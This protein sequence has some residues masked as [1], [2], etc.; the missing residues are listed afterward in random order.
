MVRSRNHMNA[1][2]PITRLLEAYWRQPA[3]APVHPQ[4][5]K[6]KVQMTI[7]RLAFVYE[8]IRNVIDYKDEHLIRKNA[9]ERMLKRRLYTEDKKE[10]FGLLLVEELIRAGYLANNV[11]PERVIGEIDTIIEKYLRTLLAVAPN[12]LTKDRR[13][14]VNWI[15]SVCATEIE[16][17]L[18]PQIKQD[19]L[20]ESMYAVL[21][22]D[23]DLAND[24]SD[25]TERDLQVYIAIHRALIKSDWP[26]IRYHLLNF[27]LPGWLESD[28]RAIEY[29]TQNFE[30]LHDV[31]ERQVNHPLG[32]RL[33]R[34][35]KRF[36]V[37]FVIM[38]DLLEKHGPNFQNLIHDQEEFEKEIRA[39]CE[40]RYKHANVRLRRSYVRTIIYVFFTKMLLA[41]LLELPYEIY[42]LTTTYYLPLII[43]IAFHPVLMFLIAVSIRVPSTKNTDKIVELLHKIVHQNPTEGFLYKKKKTFGRSPFTEVIFTIFYFIMFV[44]TFGAIIYALYLLRFNIVSAVLF[45][46]FLSVISFFGMK[47]RSQVKELVIIDQKDS[48]ISALIDFVSLPILRVGQ[49]VAAKTPKVNLFLFVLDFIIEAPFKMFMEVIEDWIV[50]QREKKEEIF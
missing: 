6:V 29:F 27:Y 20:V 44:V 33:F 21:R 4:E 31:I 36:S 47:L 5:P 43:N 35:V 19:A 37:L 28:P 30:A 38:G 40:V 41:L 7:S 9:I 39:A 49:W 48:I 16:H 42:V 22:K 32:D 24:I 8:K 15:L 13:A 23:V 2:Q 17:K 46:F 25:P 26:I 50:F 18:V 34:F 14:A 3:Q 45:L 11:L 1:S 12:R 10:H